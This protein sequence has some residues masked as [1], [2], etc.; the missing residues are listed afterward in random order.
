MAHARSCEILAKHAKRKTV[1]LQGLRVLAL[2]TKDRFDCIAREGFLREASSRELDSAL[3]SSTLTSDF[4]EKAIKL[5]SATRLKK[6]FSKSMALRREVATEFSCVYLKTL[7][8]VVE[9]MT[10]SAARSHREQ[11][12]PSDVVAFLRAEA[13][14]FSG[15]GLSSS[16]GEFLGTALP[17]LNEESSAALVLAGT[18]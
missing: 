6:A 12:V 15:Y 17:S 8:S 13:R 2:C 5:I 14:E 11:I 4:M 7:L 18:R 1:H 3:V 9:S 10:T 16:G